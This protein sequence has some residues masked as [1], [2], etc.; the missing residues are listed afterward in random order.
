MISIFASGTSVLDIPTHE[1]RDIKRD[2]EIVTTNYPVSLIEPLCISDIH[3]FGDI[4]TAKYADEYY[5]DSNDTA[6]M[7]R[8]LIYHHYKHHMPHITPTYIVDGEKY[9]PFRETTFLLTLQA[10]MDMYP[11]SPIRVYGLDF[12]IGKQYNRWYDKYVEEKDSRGNKKFTPE[13]YD[14]RLN[15]R[16]KSNGYGADSFSITFKMFYAACKSKLERVSWHGKWQPT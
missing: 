12:E 9:E 10:V 16:L 8:D 1:L 4:D 5:K 3:S 6:F 13:S 14:F 15:K 7:V 2:G 11:R